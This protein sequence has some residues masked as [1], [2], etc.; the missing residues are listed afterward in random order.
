M[1]GSSSFLSTARLLL[2][3]IAIVILYTAFF[4]IPRQ[5]EISRVATETQRQSNEIK[6][7]RN[8]RLAQQN[9]LIQ[10]QTD[11]RKTTDNDATLT[12]PV[13]Q[14]DGQ[15]SKVREFSELLSIFKTHQM[16]CTSV[17]LVRDETSEASNESTHCVS[18]N[19]SFY[20]MLSALKSI[21]L[22]LPFAL[23]TEL[24]MAH[25]DPAKECHW[26]ISLQLE[27]ERK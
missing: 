23:T 1:F 25:S 7:L 11:N 9:D 12:Q 24:S 22:S 16:E 5:R 20:D 6:K 18:L 17:E 21:E 3:A 26:K 13:S 4:A 14:K 19:G 27:P 8:Q 2:P 10:C 15:A